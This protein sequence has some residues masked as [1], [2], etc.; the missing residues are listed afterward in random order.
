MEIIMKIILI[1]LG[2]CLVVGVSLGFN[3]LFTY[4]IIWVINGIFSVNSW[5]KFW[6]IFWGLWIIQWI[7]GS[8]FKRS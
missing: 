8:I 3:W 2:I 1:I 6:Y 5:D 4:G 7:L